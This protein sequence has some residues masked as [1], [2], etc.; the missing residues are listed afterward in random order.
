MKTIKELEKEIRILKEQKDKNEEDFK[1]VCYYMT[2]SFDESSKEMRKEI[3]SLKNSW[4]NKE[5][6]LI[7]KKIR[8]KIT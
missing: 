2:K 1:S 5:A 6:D 3:E 7:L 4:A 8:E